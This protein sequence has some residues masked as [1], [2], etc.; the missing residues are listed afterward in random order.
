MAIIEQHVACALL[1]VQT[2]HKN[3]ESYEIHFKHKSIELHNGVEPNQEVQTNLACPINKEKEN[4]MYILACIDRVFKN[5]S[6]EI[7]FH[8]LK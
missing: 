7:F 2:L 4:D 1:W 8:Q 3:W 6:T 5:S